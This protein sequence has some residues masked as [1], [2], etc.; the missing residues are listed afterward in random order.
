MRG[1]HRAAL[2]LPLILGLAGA[3]H[4]PAARAF[5]TLGMSWR[6]GRVNYRINPN[7][8]DQDLSGTRE[9]Q[10]ELISCSAESWREQSVAD[11]RFVYLG[12]TTATGLNDNDGINTVS[13]SN[14]DGGDAL[15]VTLISGVGSRIEGFDMVLFSESLG[16][17]NEWSGPQ[18]PPSGTMDLSLIHI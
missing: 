14:Q 9:Q 18:D 13:W 10:V 1:F 5:E 4:S 12:T 2:I 3:I 16:T 15:A 11:L 6:T 7:F 17:A 8:P